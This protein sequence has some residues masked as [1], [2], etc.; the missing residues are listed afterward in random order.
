MN[1]EKINKLFEAVKRTETPEA[2]PRFTDD[3]VR[4]I[5]GQSRAQ[6]P[7]LLDQIGSLFPQ[8]A[9]AAALTI[10]VC[11][12]VDFYQSSRDGALS[13][14]IQLLTDEWLLAAQ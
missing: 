2:S 6:K 1:D 3:V 9:C 12:A 4:A 7:G 5:S 8:F 11:V 13:S 10:T 14:E